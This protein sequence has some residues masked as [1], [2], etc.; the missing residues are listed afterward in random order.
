LI[1]VSHS[2]VQLGRWVGVMFVATV[3]GLMFAQRGVVNPITSPIDFRAFYCA[4]RAVVARADPYRVEPARSCQAAAI[5]A[6]DLRGIRGLTVPTPQPPYGLAFFSL[7]AALPFLFASVLW[8]ALSVT[9]WLR[10]V[11]LLRDMTGLDVAWPFFATFGGL[12]LLGSFTVGQIV[13][14]LMWLV[15]ECAAALH[16]GD[17]RRA[18]V[19]ATLSTIE[20]A[21]GGALWLTLFALRPGARR[22]LAFGAA[23]L[24]A[25]SLL[26]LRPELS[27]EW[28]TQVLPAHAS[29]ELNNPE[30]FSL[31]SVLALAGV[32]AAAAE[33]LGTLDY[34]A[35][36]VLGIWAAAQTAARW[37]EPAVIALLPPAFVVLGGPY[38]HQHHLAMAIPMA[39]LAF[40]QTR[41]REF[42]AAIVLLGVPWFSFSGAVVAQMRHGGA[43]IPAFPPV[44]PDDLAEAVWSHYITAVAAALPP[45]RLLAL[46]MLLFKLPQWLG[47]A[48]VVVPLLAASARFGATRARLPN[49]S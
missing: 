48:L 35:M 36:I 34:A 42:V 4:G 20:P 24:L 30:Q 38:V 18:A 45:G 8:F 7:F 12:A 31:S 6:A 41:R 33:A 1:G 2:M 21:T 22:T 32:P 19:I 28:L 11:F 17:E 39:L 16:A 43:P 25:V 15:A 29:S 46:L 37:H 3:V 14:V 47:V 9:A 5:S 49:Q 27:V 44:R 13:P 40:A 26:A 23:A 10:T